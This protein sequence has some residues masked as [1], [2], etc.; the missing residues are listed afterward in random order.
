MLADRSFRTMAALTT[1]FAFIM[2]IICLVHFPDLAHR[3]NKNSTS[4]GGKAYV[5]SKAPLS[6]RLPKSAARVH[7]GIVVPLEL[8]A[9][10]NLSLIEIRHVRAWKGRMS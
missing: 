3:A 4:V 7:R 1:V 10:A 8:G 6:C 5:I 2:I 9:Q